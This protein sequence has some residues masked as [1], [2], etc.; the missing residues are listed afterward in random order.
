MPVE[1]MYATPV[2]SRMIGRSACWIGYGAE[3]Q[4]SIM[5]GTPT[6]L[7][8]GPRSSFGR[9]TSARTIVVRFCAGVSVSGQTSPDAHD[10]LAHLLEDATCTGPRATTCSDVLRLLEQMVRLEDEW[11][12]A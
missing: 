8:A 6:L 5:S 4:S 10:P 12:A 1:L 2:K 7:A 3:I 11:V 9:M